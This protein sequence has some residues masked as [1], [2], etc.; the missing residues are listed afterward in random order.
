M[1]TGALAPQAGHVPLGMPLAGSLVR[2]SAPDGDISQDD[3]AVVGEVL[4]GGPGVGR[5]YLA[6]PA[7]TAL[8]FRPDPDSGIPGARRYLTG[9]L[10][11]LLGD[12]NLV[13]LGRND[14]QVKVLG[15]RLELAEVDRALRT[16]SGVEDAAACLDAR[17]GQVGAFL[18]LLG[19][20]PPPGG[21]VPVPREHAAELSAALASRLP[22]WAVPARFAWIDVLPVTVNGKLDRAALARMLDKLGAD[23]PTPGEGQD[24]VA[25]TRQPGGELVTAI[26]AVL[27]DVLGEASLAAD[28][29]FFRHGGNSILAMQAAT[30]LRDRVGLAGLRA[31]DLF[32]DRTATRLSGRLAG[33]ES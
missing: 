29:D 10:G 20:T 18:R 19:Q 23:S 30:M 5:G 9:D 4:L 16:L 14:A 26:L 7:Q 32:D 12:G 1:Y 6:D 22:S 24:R 27:R 25:M 2:L 21:A 33:D 8:R 31:R 15:H 13:F 11:R 28:D 3:Q 17:T